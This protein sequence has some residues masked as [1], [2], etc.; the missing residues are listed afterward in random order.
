VRERRE[1]DVLSVEKASTTFRDKHAFKP[2]PLG[3]NRLGTQCEGTE[4]RPPRSRQVGPP[5]TVF[6][7]LHVT[8]SPNRDN[9]EL[10]EINDLPI[11]P[12]DGRIPFNPDFRRA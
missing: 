6:I 7:R 3:I 9:A 4:P 5:L 12:V 1:D 8:G 11:E 2:L 10:G